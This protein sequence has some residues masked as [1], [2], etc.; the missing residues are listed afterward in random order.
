MEWAGGGDGWSLWGWLM[1]MPQKLEL[2][3]LIQPHFPQFM[4]LGVLVQV[5][6]Q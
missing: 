3:G 6:K 5:T 1:V 4:W 2:K